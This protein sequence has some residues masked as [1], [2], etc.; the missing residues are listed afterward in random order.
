MME[1]SLRMILKMYG[2][3]LMGCL[4]CLKSAKA[5]VFSVDQ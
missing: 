3:G 1:K 5:D 2:I 4:L